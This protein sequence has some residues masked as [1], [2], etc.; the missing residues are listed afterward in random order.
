MSNVR[1]SVHFYVWREVISALTL[2]QNKTNFKTTNCLYILLL[3][4]YFVHGS[5]RRKNILMFLTSVIQLRL[6]FLWQRDY[7]HRLANTGSLKR[8]EQKRWIGH[9]QGNINHV[10]S[11]IH[12]GLF[13]PSVVMSEL[14]GPGR[15]LPY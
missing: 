3:P 15:W 13:Q 10:Q 1:L 7:L 8:M 11:I 6:W 2:R 4:N 5:D 12:H 14:S 9:Y